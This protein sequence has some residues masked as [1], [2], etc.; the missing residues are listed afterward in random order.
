LAEILSEEF[1]EQVN[2]IKRRHPGYGGFFEVTI[3]PTNKVIWDKI[4]T[5]SRQVKQIVD[6]VR[7]YLDSKN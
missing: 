4:F 1:P 6:K 3:V 7:E 5:N 2:V